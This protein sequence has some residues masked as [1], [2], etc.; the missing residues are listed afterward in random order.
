M[1]SPQDVHQEVEQLR[2]QLADA[3]EAKAVAEDKAG[4]C[5]A[6]MRS[7]LARELFSKEALLSETSAHNMLSQEVEELH[8]QLTE[9]AVASLLQLVAELHDPPH[10]EIVWHC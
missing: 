9:S 2:R 8:A 7:C 4:S 6:E 10:S 3:Q 5:E 1:T